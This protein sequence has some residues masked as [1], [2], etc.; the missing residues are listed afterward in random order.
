M[1]LHLF[2]TVIGIYKMYATKTKHKLKN[3]FQIRFLRRSVDK[4]HSIIS[5]E[6]FKALFEKSILF[7]NF[8]FQISTC[9]FQFTVFINK[10]KMRINI[11][12]QLIYII[13]CNNQMLP[14]F[15]NE[16]ILKWQIL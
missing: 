16:V 10:S 9:F 4:A 3:R 7:N 13:R 8:S 6:Y 12:I 14:E 5:I 15:A 11:Q 1:S 2:N